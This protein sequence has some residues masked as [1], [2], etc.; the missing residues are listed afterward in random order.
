MNAIVLSSSFASSNS[1]WYLAAL[2]LVVSSFS[3]TLLLRLVKG[4]KFPKWILVVGPA[5]G[6]AFT[7]FTL[8]TSEGLHGTC[9][10][11][12]L[13]DSGATMEQNEK[14]RYEFVADKA[15]L[16]PKVGD[17]VP[18]ILTPSFPGKSSPLVA[19]P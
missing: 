12:Y 3:F 1:D 2:L 5:L 8:Y 6:A 17:T 13:M 11:S 18:Y 19:S 16:C 4:N 15:N 9:K 14:I 7:A 10:I